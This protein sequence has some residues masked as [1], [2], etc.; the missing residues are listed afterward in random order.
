MKEEKMELE[1]LKLIFDYSKAGRFPDHYFLDKV[2]EI[3]VKK[4]DLNDYVK[5][6]VFIDKL[7]GAESDKTFASYNY[8]RKQI[9]V[10]YWPI[11]IMCQ[12]NSRYDSL[13]NPIERMLYH[14]INIT[15]CILHEL[16]HAT[17]YKT[18]DDHENTSIEAKLIRTASLL[19]RTLKNPK[20]NEL[21]LS[22]K[23]SPKS[24]EIYLKDYRNL[25]KKNYEI[26]PME[27]MAQIN[28]YRTIINFLEFIKK[29][30]PMLF[31]FNCKAL[32]REKIRGYESSWQKGLCP[33]HV[34]LKNTRK[35]DVWKSFD[36]YDENQAVLI[37]KVSNEYDLNKR[38]LL[39]LPVSPDECIGHKIF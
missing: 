13:F 19:K 1:I 32:E 4:R 24:L 30:I 17:Q 9:S 22:G 18:A 28:S 8:L 38:L 10:Y 25:Y 5:N 15:Q 31:T 2:V 23:I 14:N 35:E 21:L 20:F 12:K 11:Q 7:D 3:V 6:T 16:E 29:Q 34:Y 33:T 26:N 27:R 36:F 39:G 37:K